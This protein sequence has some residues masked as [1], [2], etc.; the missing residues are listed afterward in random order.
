MIYI[1]VNDQSFVG[2]AH[3]TQDAAKLLQNLRAT[4]E[5]LRTYLGESS[6]HRPRAI[7]DAPLTSSLNLGAFIQSHEL[8]KTERTLLLQALTKGPYLDS[9]LPSMTGKALPKH[10][11]HYKSRPFP[12]TALAYA[13]HLCSPEPFCGTHSPTA[14]LSL[15]GAPDFLADDLEVEFIDEEAP[16]PSKTKQGKRK[17]TVTTAGTLRIIWNVTR[18][19]QVIDIYRRYKANDQKHPADSDLDGYVSAMDLDAK[20]AQK[21][22]AEGVLLP[23]E[24]QRRRIFGR[25][26]GKYYIFPCHDKATNEFH[27]F[28]VTA[29]NIQRRMGDV[30][31][32]LRKMGFFEH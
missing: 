2:Q 23:T 9:S 21:T 18:E 11:C 20:K 31:A 25:C 6:V 29:D 16:K 15:I 12:Y 32:Q 8:N 10:Q 17:G 30:Y 14:L 24:T 1:I 26:D 5:A 28:R 4:L 7:K 27:G 19:Q 22:L 13:A 3:T